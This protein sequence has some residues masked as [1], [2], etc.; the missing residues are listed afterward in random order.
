MNCELE[1]YKLCCTNDNEYGADMVYEL[2][3]VFP[4]DKYKH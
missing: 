4:K 1:L 2:V 3:T